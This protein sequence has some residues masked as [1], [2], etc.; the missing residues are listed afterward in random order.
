MKAS[1]RFSQNLEASPK[2]IVFCKNKFINVKKKLAFAQPQ[3]PHSSIA[4]GRIFPQWFDARFEDMKIT[5][6]SKIVWANK[7]SVDRP[8]ALYSVK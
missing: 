6:A 7:M 5:V 3:L 4:I 8:K 1:N 2:M